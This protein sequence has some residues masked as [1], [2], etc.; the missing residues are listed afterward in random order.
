MLRVPLL[1]SSVLGSWIQIQ[2]SGFDSRRYHIFWE[3]VGLEGGPLSLVSTTEELL[4]RNSSG[5]GIE[6]WESGRRDQPRWPRDILYQQKLTLTSP[7]SCGRSVGIV[8]SWT[9]AMELYRILRER[10]GFSSNKLAEEFEKLR[11]KPC[12]IQAYIWLSVS[13]L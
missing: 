2:R 13:W 11:E 3:V 8:R 5:S 12:E 1:W 6:N 4:G 9:K 10:C 7:T